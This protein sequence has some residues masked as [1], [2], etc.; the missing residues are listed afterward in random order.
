MTE[1]IRRMDSAGYDYV[2]KTSGAT[3]VINQ[4]MLTV[5]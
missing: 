5:I 1:S 3:A 2:A 4:P